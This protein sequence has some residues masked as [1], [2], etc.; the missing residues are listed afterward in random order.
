MTEVKYGLFSSEAER[1]ILRKMGV[2]Q[3]NIIP[4]SSWNSI[5]G[6]VKSADTVCVASIMSIAG[7]VNALYSI[8]CGLSSSGV[9]FISCDE[10]RLSFSSAKP[11]QNNIQNT[12]RCFAQI[13]NE[14]ISFLSNCQINA[15]HCSLAIA[16]I[17]KGS[18]QL[19]AHVFNN[20]TI[21]RVRS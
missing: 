19:L 3:R 4:V 8:L 5:S 12:I 13:E 14:N 7:N 1:I 21:Y 20:E 15:N 9:G 2:A 16:Q 11:L 17:Q 18:M 10:K 6:G